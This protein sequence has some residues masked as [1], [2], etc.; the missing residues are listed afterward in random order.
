[1]SRTRFALLF[2]ERI[3]QPPVGY[4]TQLRLESVAQRLRESDDPL[5]EIAHAVGFLSQ[6]GLSRAFRRRFG[7]TPS[8]FRKE[9][10]GG[11]ASG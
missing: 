5:S 8:A 4:L 2:Q 10:R 11:R 1:M 3:G 6:S 7:Q 9:A